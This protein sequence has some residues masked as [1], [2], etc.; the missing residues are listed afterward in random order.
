MIDTGLSKTN[1]KGRI[2]FKDRSDG[3]R[4]GIRILD[5]YQNKNKIE[6]IFVEK[7]ANH[8][9][10]RKKVYNVFLDKELNKGEC[11]RL[12]ME[13]VVEQLIETLDL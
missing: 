10:T 8:G 11:T 12:E 9:R 5:V 3:P 6:R 13:T 4:L 1:G 7:F 2:T